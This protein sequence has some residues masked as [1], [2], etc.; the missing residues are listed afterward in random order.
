MMT[1]RK[2]ITKCK[3]VI[4]G[5]STGELLVSLMGEVGKKIWM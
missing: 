1:L 4:V 5:E 2:S 3:E